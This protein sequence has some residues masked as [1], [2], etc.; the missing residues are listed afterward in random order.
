MSK[1]ICEYCGRKIKSEDDC[2]YCGA[3]SSV[4]A[5]D[6]KQDDFDFSFGDWDEWW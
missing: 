1:V 4:R 6:K 5:T 3:P 2:Q